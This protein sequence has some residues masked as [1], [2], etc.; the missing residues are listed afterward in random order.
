[1]ATSKTLDPKKLG[2]K[3][4]YQDGKLLHK[5]GKEAGTFCKGYLRVSIDY[6]TYPVHRVIWTLLNGEDPGPNQ[7]DH[8]DRDKLNNSI[9]NLR[10]VTNQ[11]N[12]YNR[13]AKGYRK[14]SNGYQAQIKVNGKLLNVGL[15]QTPDEAHSVYQNYKNNLIHADANL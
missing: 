12:Q 15:Y 1:M 3:F 7:V 8:I 13:V 2:E 9:E 5:N 14:R 4:S 6:K 10:L 11:I